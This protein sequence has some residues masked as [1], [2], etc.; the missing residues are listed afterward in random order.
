MPMSERG[1]AEP[2]EVSSGGRAVS[3]GISLLIHS[4]PLCLCAILGLLWLIGGR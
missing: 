3:R 2:G 1:V 4:A